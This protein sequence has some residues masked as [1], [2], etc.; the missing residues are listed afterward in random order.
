M[1]TDFGGGARGPSAFNQGPAGMAVARL[2]D[3]SLLT[4]LSRRVCRRSSAQGVH[5][6]SRV[7]DPGEVAEF[8]YGGHRASELYPAQSLERV[9]DRGEPP[10]L[11]LVGEG[12]CQTRQ[13]CGVVGARSDGCLAHDLLCRGGTDHCAEPPEVGGTPGGSARR[14]DSVSQEKGF[15]L[16]FCSL[17]STDS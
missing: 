13:P 15:A 7:I 16:E 9:D 8:G 4:P 12:L 1:P 2:G 10:G 14:T 17:E 5:Q 3:A 11:H 6:L